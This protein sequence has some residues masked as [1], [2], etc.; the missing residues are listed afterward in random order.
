MV[1]AS[2]LRGAS[3]PTHGAKG[4]WLVGLLSDDLED[5]REE[6]RET[7]ARLDSKRGVLQGQIAAAS[8]GKRRAPRMMAAPGVHVPPP[9][10]PADDHGA[11]C[12]TRKGAAG[13]VRRRLRANARG[14]KEARERMEAL[15]G[16]LEEALVDARESLALQPG[17]RRTAA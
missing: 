1:V 3:E 5:L 9:L 2:S 17:G 4:S 8:L 11:C 16:D 6:L 7:L 15:L 13:A 14:V 10:P 12:Y